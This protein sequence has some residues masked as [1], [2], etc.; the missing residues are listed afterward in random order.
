MNRILRLQITFSVL[1]IRD[2]LQII[3]KKKRITQD[4]LFKLRV[5]ESLIDALD[6]QI[7]VMNHN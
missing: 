2:V 1:M 4:D 7:K 6:T 5:M 3:K